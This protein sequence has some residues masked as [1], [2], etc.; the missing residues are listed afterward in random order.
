MI[1][2]SIIEEKIN[3]LE[4]YLYLLTAHIN[5]AA[6]IN[7]IKHI[8][9]QKKFILISSVSIQQNNNRVYRKKN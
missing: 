8:N 6:H 4:V 7:A 1:F 9:L 5:V 2:V 3:L